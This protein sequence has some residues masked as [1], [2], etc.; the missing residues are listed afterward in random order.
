MAIRCIDGTLNIPE[1]WDVDTEIALRKEDL[2]PILVPTSVMER[3]QAVAKL[4]E[5]RFERLFVGSH[6]SYGLL[7]RRI[8]KNV[9]DPTVVAYCVEQR[10]PFDTMILVGAR[11]LRGQP[12]R[13]LIAACVHRKRNRVAKNPRKQANPPSS[14]SSIP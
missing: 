14:K 1:F 12:E 4:N 13:Q 2:L 7:L 10:I 6:R 11:R 9:T 5:D 8:G 3:C